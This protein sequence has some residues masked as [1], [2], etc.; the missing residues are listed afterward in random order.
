MMMIQTVTGNELPVE[1][2]VVFPQFTT[3]KDGDGTVLLRPAVHIHFR[4]HFVSDVIRIVF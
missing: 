3:H 2:A 4:L 1:H